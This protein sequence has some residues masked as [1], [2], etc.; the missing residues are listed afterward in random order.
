MGFWNA[1]SVLGPVGPALSDAQDIRTQRT[2]DA[3]KAAQEAESHKAQ[4]IVQ[5]LAAQEAQQRI[6]AGTQPLIKPGSQP[7]FNPASGTY[8]QPEWVPDKE[9]YVSRDVPGATPQE[10]EKYQLD[11]LR[12][13]RAAAKE[14]MPDATPEQLDYLSYTLSGVKP[15]PAKGAY[16]ALTGAAG[17]PRL[18]ADGKSYVRDMYDPATNS[19]V[20]MPMPADYKPPEPKPGT[21]HPGLSHGRNAFGFFNPGK[22]QWQDAAGNAMPD[23]RPQTTFAETGLF[24]PMASYNP[25]TESIAMGSFNRRTGGLTFANG[26]GSSIPLPPAI[27]AT[28]GKEFGVA[29][30]AQTRFRIMQ[31][32]AQEAYQGNQ[33]AMV[34][35]LM[36][37]IGMTLGAQKGTHVSKATINDAERSAP[38]LETKL[39]S[40]GHRDMNG[41]FIYDGP[42]G[43]TN[44]T[45]QQV[46]QMVDLARQ[47]NDLQ[48]Q[49]VKD[50]GATYGVDLSG[51][52][53]QT[54]GATAPEPGPRAA[55][56]TGS[57]TIP[58]KGTVA[59]HAGGKTY[60][61]PRSQVAEFKKDHPDARQ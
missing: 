38:W 43:G 11:S 52:I 33:Q 35:L 34:S 49:Q 42:K 26:G 3:A 14:M 9:S 53:Q 60:N 25:Q 57:H 22:K 18:A 2:Q 41:D 29:R 59:L 16:R 37:H 55:G 10:Q 1:L 28:I 13:N 45:G 32:N 48:W 5:Q 54:Q 36:N 23:F 58:P 44:L 4:M 39:S 61:I 7:E 21:P 50:T 56:G 8:Q 30:D 6:R 27:A 15:P 40:I 20:E 19:Q 31:Q 12:K 51:A 47:R 17:Q 24:E 46:G